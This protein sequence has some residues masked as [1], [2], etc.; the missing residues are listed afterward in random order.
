[1]TGLRDEPLQPRNAAN[2]EP[3]KLSTN[4]QLVETNDDYLIGNY[5]IATPRY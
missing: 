2:L 5:S 4:S 3:L 1:M